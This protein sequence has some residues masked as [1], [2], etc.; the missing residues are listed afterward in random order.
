M[1]LRSPTE[2]QNEGS[3]FC[4]GIPSARHSRA[5]GNPGLLSAEL[6]W[7]P[8]FAGMTKEALKWRSP[9]DLSDEGL[10]ADI[11]KRGGKGEEKLCSTSASGNLRRRKLEDAGRN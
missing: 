2:H 8:A 10:I 4:V 6:A 9:L 1:I 7:I 5:R 11:E 3:F